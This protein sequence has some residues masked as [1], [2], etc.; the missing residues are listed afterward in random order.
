MPKNCPFF[1]TGCLWMLLAVMEFVDRGTAGHGVFGGYKWVI[2]LLGS[3]VFFIN[4]YRWRPSPP[5]T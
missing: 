4:A 5:P 2:W 3:V 1:A